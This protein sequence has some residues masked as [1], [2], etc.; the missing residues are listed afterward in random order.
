MKRIGLFFQTIFTGIAAA[1]SRFPLTSAALTGACGLICYMIWLDNA[2]PVTI[3]KL[4]LTLL[5]AAVLGMTVQFGMERFRQSYRFRWAVYSVAVLLSGGYFG[6]LWPASEINLEIG[7]RTTVA[8][9]ALVCLT[10]WLPALRGGADFNHVALVHFKSLFTS[11]LYAAVLTG[12]LAA[13]IGAIDVLLV[14][15]DSNTYSY[16]MAVVWVLFATMYYLSLL[17]EFDGKDTAGKNEAAGKYPRFLEIL[18]SYIAIPLVGAYT[19]VLLAYFIKMLAT[20]TW[21]SGQLGPMVLAYSAAGLIIFVLASLPENRFAALYRKIFPKALIPAVIMQLI[22]VFIRLEAYGV[23]ESRYYVALFG[24]FSFVIAVLLSIKPTSKNAMIALL[25]ALFAVVSILPPVDAF[26]VSRN[27]QIARLENI[28]Q[29]DGI[30]SGETLL[31]KADVA[32]QDRIE[33]TNILAY[34]DTRGYMGSVSWLPEGFTA[35]EDM[36]NVLGFAPAYSGSNSNQQNYY[37]SLDTQQAL[38][39]T[40]YDVETQLSS[41]QGESIGSASKT[42]FS[43][44]GVDYILTMT[45]QSDYEVLISVSEAGANT[46]IQTGLYDF[47]QSIPALKENK[48]TAPP[49][50]M[51]LQVEQNGYKLKIVFKS[52]GISEGDSANGADYDVTVLFGA[53]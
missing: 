8:V 53:P 28:L 51:T 19:L 31:P 2:P 6:L 30:L 11:A 18:I 35:Y 1:V 20:L 36:E 44:R 21:P 40:G 24:I 37:L 49:E 10:L 12:G 43:L 27:S 23:T 7:I 5:V 42:A 9:F 32:E 4:M 26:S 22:S 25:A 38:P 47:A 33:V 17:P 16:M 3:Y 50:D 15:V 34:L 41:Y 45:R 29:T 48:A 46:L 39:I 52:I 13:V 14:R